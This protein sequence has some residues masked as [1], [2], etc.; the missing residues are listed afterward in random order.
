MAFSDP[1]WNMFTYDIGIDLGTANTLVC[2]RNQGV[3]ISEP[4]VVAFN[5]K[6]KTVLAVGSEAQKMLGRTP[7]S[8][9]A[10]RPLKDGVISDFDATREMIKYFIEKVHKDSPKFF[11]IPRPRVVIG[12]PSAITEVEKK[13]VIDAAIS[14]GARKVYLIEE[15]MA[16]AVGIN[17]PVT[18]PLGSLIVD[19]GGGTSDIA[20][21][22]LGGIVVDKSIR[23]AGDEMTV[24]IV[25]YI[26]SKYN[27]LIGER[28]A[29][30]IKIKLG[31]AYPRKDNKSMEI[32]GRDILLGLPKVI[33]ISEV[34]IRE[35][36]SNSL[37]IIIEAISEALEETPPELIS[38]ITNNGIYLTGG[39]A[40]ISGINKLFLEK[41]KIPIMIADDPL[42]S[43][44]LGASK[45]LEDL[46]LLENIS[47][48]DSEE[49][50]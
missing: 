14:A 15:P 37:N 48:S 4:S 2:V 32:K 3:T 16:A 25:N 7:A 10:I 44:V 33:K 21:I 47:Y 35:A 24:D 29:E 8:I 11:K 6:T 42:S 9:V 27:L 50:L 1:F 34:E 46:S 36:M 20:V 5:S 30:E 40:Q 13:A 38:D 28:T 39:G 26:R 49:F 23:V 22:S 45:I 17:V 18:E 19:I 43:V 41:L 31:N 12:I